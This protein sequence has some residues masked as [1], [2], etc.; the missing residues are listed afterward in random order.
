MLHRYFIRRALLASPE[1][2]KKGGINIAFIFSVVRVVW[3]N[4]MG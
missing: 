3:L 1:V 2:G 4:Y